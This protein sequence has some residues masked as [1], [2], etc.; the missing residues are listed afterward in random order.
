VL[1]GAGAVFLSLR[2]EPIMVELTERPFVVHIVLGS[3]WVAAFV[4]ALVVV[5]KP[6][7]DR[8]RT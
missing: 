7:V 3:L 4:P 5:G 8:V 2:Y 6:L 1:A